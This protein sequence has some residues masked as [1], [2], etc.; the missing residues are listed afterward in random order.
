MKST[1]NDGKP[2]DIT[3]NFEILILNPVQAKLISESQL[4][5]F[6]YPKRLKKGTYIISDGESNIG[7]VT[8]T[9]RPS[10]YTK[11]NYTDSAK[12]QNNHA[13][14]WWDSIRTLYTHQYTF[15]PII[16]TMSPLRQYNLKAS[17]FPV[18]VHVI[19]QNTT[20]V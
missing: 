3:S 19:P 7:T 9:S 13:V 10:R 5:S 2:A 18:K 1:T 12:Q 14:E 4:D 16:D 15:H 6:T 17:M 11:Q 8:L 20:G